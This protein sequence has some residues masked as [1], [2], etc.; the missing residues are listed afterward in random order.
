[1]TVILGALYEE[2]EGKD[3]QQGLVVGADTFMTTTI[4]GS[5]QAV[6]TAET[7]KIRILCDGKAAF[8]HTG[9]M[10]A[11]QRIA[12]KLEKWVSEG[13]LHK[14]RSADV[15]KE[16]QTKL[17]EVFK[18][19]PL[20]ELGQSL[21]PAGGAMLDARVYIK[22]SVERLGGGI[23]AVPT[24]DG[25]AAFS[26]EGVDSISTLERGR[27]EYCVN[28]SGLTS[29]DSFLDFVHRV[30]WH[31]KIPSRRVCMLGV[32][33][34]IRH[35]IRR[36]GS[37]GV[38]GKPHLALLSFRDGKHPKFVRV[39]GGDYEQVVAEVD[40]LEKKIGDLPEG[41]IPKESE[42]PSPPAAA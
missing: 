17:V 21:L 3:Q 4:P 22:S 9:E 20:I 16:L 42:V 24:E 13:S 1:M 35:A 36:G 40:A 39:E 8:L 10:G 18:G 37:S 25:L 28:G 6:G 7:D 38:G 30:V 41:A 12:S 5:D 23:F 19:D 34:T 32:F 11:G 33:W 15:S 31:S 29:G 2:G 14:K 27:R 26:F